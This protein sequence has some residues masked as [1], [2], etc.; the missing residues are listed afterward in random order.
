MRSIEL[1]NLRTQRMTLRHHLQQLDHGHDGPAIGA[2]PW[3]HRM[4]LHV[5]NP[6]V[7]EQTALLHEHSLGELQDLFRCVVKVAGLAGQL[8][9]LRQAGNTHI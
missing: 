2:R 4:V 8:A 3:K 5:L 6:A 7:H 9:R 1:Q